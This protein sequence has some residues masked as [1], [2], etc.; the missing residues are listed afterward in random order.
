MQ[1][2]LDAK[3][4]SPDLYAYG[5]VRLIAV[6]VKAVSLDAHRSGWWERL[7]QRGILP[8]V[9][10]KRKLA[11]VL[12]QDLLIM[13][14][15]LPPLSLE[16]AEQMMTE[17]S[18]TIKAKQSLEAVLPLF[19]QHNLPMIPIVDD[20]GQY[21]GECASYTQWYR[22]QHGLLRPSR[23]GGFATP[24]GVYL[25][26]GAISGG[27]GW[28]ALIA[29]AI[30]FGVM[31]H[32]L[33][34]I[35]LVAFSG[36]AALWPGLN[37]MDPWQQWMIQGN[38]AVVVL[39]AAMRFSALSGLHAAEHMTVSALELDLPLTVENVNAQSREHVRCGTNLMVLLGSLELLGYSLWFLHEKV[40]WLGLV[41][42]GLVWIALTVKLWRPMGLMVQ[43][44]F[45]TKP[46]TSA[47]LASG[48]KAGQQVLEQFIRTPHG[49]PSFWQR[50]W[51]SRMLPLFVICA[52]TTWIL[53]QL[54]RLLQ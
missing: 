47:Q 18:V 12:R 37:L 38:I 17:P 6:P 4:S 5:S 19:E 51:G 22:L 28:K 27:A 41:L 8:V 7:S 34:W 2:A 14:H 9:G 11:G 21:T 3:R 33:D 50:L 45:T 10:K 44:Y 39:F 20:K 30:L 43:R 42:Y 32:L 53:E 52:L 1:T 54:I 23:V 35:A 24:F 13:A 26:S 16:Q 31:V 29:T 49:P 48:I 46:P 25:T 36:L 40:N 15:S